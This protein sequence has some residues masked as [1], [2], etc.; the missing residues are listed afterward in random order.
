M[1]PCEK[2]GCHR[3]DAQ[4][5]AVGVML[6]ELHQVLVDRDHDVE[7]ELGELVVANAVVNAC[8]EK[9]D[10]LAAKDWAEKLVAA[11][12]SLR[13]AQLAWAAREDAAK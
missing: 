13:E 6:C 7:L 5:N 9:G 12:N 10:Y 3:E 8:I 2:R 11:T 4:P 1:L